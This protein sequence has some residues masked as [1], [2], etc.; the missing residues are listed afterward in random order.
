MEQNQEN[1]FKLFFVITLNI[2]QDLFI[3]LCYSLILAFL[4]PTKR[5]LYAF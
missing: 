3:L 1:H 5:S 2:L 4:S